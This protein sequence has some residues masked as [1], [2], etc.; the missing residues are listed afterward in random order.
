MGVP[1]WELNERPDRLFWM[2][3]ALTA[4]SAESEAREMWKPKQGQMVR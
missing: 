2:S 4:E 1:A 3:K